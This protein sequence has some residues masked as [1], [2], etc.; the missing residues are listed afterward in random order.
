M[1][2]VARLLGATEPS[3][4]IPF[5][6][7]RTTRPRMVANLVKTGDENRPSLGFPGGSM[8]AVG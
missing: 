8:E 6:S 3:P 7:G 1:S 5:E 2:E 4:L